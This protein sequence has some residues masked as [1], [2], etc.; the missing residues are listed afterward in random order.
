MPDR[1]LR[2]RGGTV[3]DGTGR[4]SEPVA[5][6]HRRPTK[7]RDNKDLLHDHDFLQQHAGDESP[8][9]VD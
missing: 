4:P 3:I 1:W 6:L 9:A 5:F 7:M 2:I 8:G